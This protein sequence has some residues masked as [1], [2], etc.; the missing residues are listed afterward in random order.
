MS[1]SLQENSTGELAFWTEILKDA[2]AMGGFPADFRRGK[3]QK[4]LG[5]SYRGQLSSELGALLVSMSNSSDYALFVLLLTGVQY[6]LGSYQNAAE[7]MVVMPVFRQN[8]QAELLINRILPLVSRLSGQKT[9]KELLTNTKQVVTQA[10]TNQNFPVLNYLALNPGEGG[11]PV[12]STCV[13]LE[14]VQDRAYLEGFDQDILFIFSRNEQIIE[15]TMEYN[16]L[17]YK[18]ETIG[19]IF[20]QLSAFFSTAAQRPA[21]ELPVDE[22]ITP[23]QRAGIL[24]KL[25]VLQNSKKMSPSSLSRDQVE[26][27][28]IDL[29]KRQLGTEEI[30]P[31]DDF[32]YDLG[33]NSL[34]AINVMS[35]VSKEFNVEI[36]VG[37][38]F[39][40]PT[41]RNM[42]QCIINAEAGSYSPILPVE[43]KENYA[44][45]AA[46]KRMYVLN[47]I[48]G[49]GTEYNIPSAVSIIG[50][51]D[52]PRVTQVFTSLMKRH[53]G[54]RTSF[55]PDQ[56]GEPLQVVQEAADLNIDYVDYS[57]EE[58]V[59]EIYP[60]VTHS[61]IRRFIR[62]FELE[63]APLFRVT[64][65]KMAQ[66]R[67]LLLLDAHH[68]ISDGISI[69][70]ITREFLSLYQGKDL[71][72]LRIQYKD[73]SC[74]Q[75][76]L[77]ES[78]AMRR[79]EAY[80]LNAFAGELPVLD[81]PSDY[82]RPSVQSLE[83][84]TITFLADGELT[85]RLKELAAKT[86]STLYMVLL[87][88][89]VT[90]LHKYTGQ[91]DIVVGA[92][93]AGRLHAD[94]ENVVGMFVNTL[95][96]R[97]RPSPDKSFREFLMEVRE[98]TLQAFENQSYQFERL[99]EKLEVK[100]DMSRNPIFDTLF[101][102]QNIE[103][104]SLEISGLELIPNRFETG[105]S[106]F[107]MVLAAE[108]TEAGL[109]FSFEYCL[110]LYKKERME[111][112]TEHFMNLLRSITACCDRT[113]SEMDMLSD[114]ERDRI[115]L[116]FNN[117]SAEYD[118][119][120]TVLDLFE[121]QAEKEPGNRAVIFAGTTMTYGELNL[122]ATR[123][124]GFLSRE[125]IQPG[126]IVGL[127]LDR[128][129]DMLV[130]ILG[131][132]KAGG[133]YMPIDP[134]YPPDRISFMLQDS[135][136]EILLTQSV[137]GRRPD[138]GG[139]I[140]CLLEEASY[141]QEYSD[142]DRKSNKAGPHDLAY[143][144]YTSG[145]TGRPKGVMLEHYSLM[146]RLNWMQKM[147]PI[148][149]GDVILQKTPYTFDVS[150]WELLWW[151]MQGAAVC[152]LKPGE[153]KD[154]QAIVE[155]VEKCRVTTMHFV[156]SMMN[157]FLDYIDIAPEKNRLL[158]GLKSLRQV[159]AS[160]EA[161]T[162]SQARKF[163]RLLNKSAGTRL[164]NLYG[165]TEAA[166]DVSFFDCSN[167]GELETIPIGK[168]IDNISL[169]VLDKGRR[170]Q[171]VGVQGELYIAGH[172][173]AR[174]YL[175]RPELTAERFVDNP[176]RPG[177]RMY[178]T[179]D[180]ARWLPDGN[181][182]YLGRLD[183]QVK[184]RGL[185]I[186][187]GEIEAQL[188]KH[189]SIS[190]AVVT[191]RA[192]GGGG[193][194]ICAH[195]VAC[196]EL[197]V[198]ELREHLERMLPEYMIPS[199]FVQLERLPVTSNGK[200]DS[201]SLPEP[202]RNNSSPSEFLAPQTLVER[203]LADIYQSVLGVEKVGINDN[204]F[205]L[206]GDSIKAIQVTAAAAQQGI[207][208]K[209]SDLLRY[210][211]I[212]ELTVNGDLDRKPELVHQ[213]QVTGSVPVTPVQQWFYELDRGYPHYW[214]QTNLF[215]I[216]VTA[217]LELLER[218][219]IK[220]IEHHD[221]LR[222]A[223]SFPEEGP[224]QYIRP[225]DAIKFELK[226]VDL[227]GLS[228]ETREQRLIE[229]SEEIQD[230]LRLEAHLPIN[231]CVFELAADERR[232]F[233]AVH[234]L[235]V[236]GVSWRILLEDIE[237]LYNSALQEELPLKTTSYKAWSEKLYGF[238]LENPVDVAYWESM[239]LSDIKPL[240]GTVN[241]QDNYLQDFR[242][243]SFTLEK[244]PS[245][246]LLGSVHRA[247]GTGINDILLSALTLALTEALGQDKVLLMLEG[248]GRQELVRDV[249]LSRTVGWFT[250]IY[251]VLLERQPYLADTIG[252][253]K[254]NL[255]KIPAG[256][257]NYG[258]ARY[259]K[260]YR[261]LEAIKPEIAFNY[262]GQFHMTSDS[263]QGLLSLCRESCGRSIH[264]GNRHDYLIDI[265][266]YVAEGKLHFSV[267]F[268]AVY[269]RSELAEDICLRLEAALLGLFEHCTA[270]AQVA[271]PDKP[272]GME[273]YQV[274]E[275]GRKELRIAVHNEITAYL[276]HSLPISVILAYEQME[277]WF[278]Q[279]YVEIFSK[280]NESGRLY[281]EFVELRAAYTDMIQEVYMGYELLEGILDII[282]YIIHKINLGF[283]VIIHI[284]E[285]YI[286]E[287]RTYMKEHY[288]HHSLV[289]GYDNNTRRLSAVGFNAQHMF[290]AISFD[291]E[292]FR[293][294]YESGRLYYM[295]SAP[296]A[297]T[298][299]IELLRPREYK[300]AYPF[301]TEKFMD[302]LRRHLASKGD[303]ATVYSLWAD[304][305]SF[306]KE[307]VKFGLE[308]Y[309]EVI[310]HM[311]NL[312]K[313]EF[314]VDYRALHV[315]FEH[316][317]ALHKR[318]C[319]I[320][321]GYCSSWQ[322]DRLLKLVDGYG[323]IVQALNDARR[324]FFEHAFTWNDSFY[325]P[326]PPKEIIR[327]VITLLYQARDREKNLLPDILKELEAGIEMSGTH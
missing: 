7:T 303:F 215:K 87:A 196:R 38:I 137:N 4:H 244:E 180:L 163:D 58:G 210:K 148:G 51:L 31:E 261:A 19:N 301:S 10:N 287:K 1:N 76:E 197:E 302:R 29:L 183:N 193:K 281:L 103:A 305:E 271:S 238:A 187:T 141:M 110:K 322:Q 297:A 253:V 12:L 213:G 190:E 120:R 25:Q 269:V 113:L 42:A 21:M 112:L 321:S 138:F 90:L 149:K 221:A 89:Y 169:Y 99:V 114:T 23:G 201:K 151:S 320:I 100:R 125:G 53:E 152:L 266:G 255:K 242:T 313:G 294:A 95:A 28:L 317:K 82:P 35:M 75:K 186:E 260:K 8:K 268:N 279:H 177:E 85:G 207:N 265:N 241:I 20:G 299:A 206:G 223:F 246:G 65:V 129:P 127:L 146:N 105:N 62:P 45:S 39:S 69:N 150:V 6:L 307:D 108:E 22:I 37:E 36:S 132:L 33:G 308:V 17:L 2:A 184:I 282:D 86:G 211:T 325:N 310:R 81:M 117:T 249:N 166:I 192:D 74:W 126:S 185:R 124:A 70:I 13:L 83:G 251:P 9:F 234:H 32:F 156:P 219:F 199:Y 318:L 27:K 264:P 182:E 309:D 232:L 300:Y 145:T 293:Q 245:Q 171:P 26:E 54:L 200:L 44:V 224:R 40:N 256:G 174:G 258:I 319:Y 170:L 47:Q 153:E 144:I 327:Q 14:N 168:P 98:N 16:A 267:K 280:T 24:Q 78:E 133:A 118:W 292:A 286:P 257:M 259:I 111:K 50:R 250:S 167:A 43:K 276:C 288:V 119:T 315:L 11:R 230:G 68:I 275:E 304:K 30:S 147:Y 106:K 97:N 158:S 202:E 161:L 272:V 298:N 59:L 142:T 5:A 218:V 143:V 109:S 231:A 205:N 254:Q 226:V 64:L 34:I 194:Y 263:S 61:I 63:K 135:G 164:H 162:V 217:D 128:C 115:L 311:D 188:L 214:N 160:G 209:V 227:R 191:A 56:N 248:H 283:Y 273:R 181:I 247:Y 278:H 222:M 285:F 212:K 130:G 306:G 243:L 91:E 216:P 71:P 178:K 140:V 233:I 284:D 270:V 203:K 41:V 104:S 49:G 123:L 204:F 324:V 80:W 131:V 314:T 139:R 175:N 93:V 121:I 18:E 179:G 136:A 176:F 3:P 66:D 165:P 225:V 173:L 73:F 96:L 15:L 235:V 46:Q 291:Y 262:L 172:G 208:V 67:H 88:A 77:L 295:D 239:D 72:E 92:P 94:L 237:G 57:E 122:K 84:G 195:F 107:D 229:A 154:P 48:H 252:F 289:Y 220:V 102:L 189:S 116:D 236:D 326:F 290:A 60:E 296:W 323:E 198:Q 101:V 240:A 159:F 316:R 228:G 155:A 274:E 312:I 55:A 79:Q 134:S 277:P 157:V 52:I